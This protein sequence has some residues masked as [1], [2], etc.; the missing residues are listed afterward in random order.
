MTGY[1]TTCIKVTPDVCTTKV[2]NSV[3]YGISSNSEDPEKAMMLLN[4]IYET[5]EANDLLNWGV[6]G[7]DYVVTEDGT[8]DYPEGVTAENV[9]YHQDYGWALMNQYNSYI[10]TGNDP[11]LWDQYKEVRDNAIVSLAYGFF[12]D[13][14]NVVNEISAVSAVSDEYLTSISSGSVDPDKAIAEF[15]EKLYNAGLQTIMDEKQT[16]LDAWLAEQQ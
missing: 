8:I 15:N 6:E 12:F 3:C 2:T 11:D 13:P 5:K 9:G 10:W 14:T 1:D 7:K 4:W 16:Q